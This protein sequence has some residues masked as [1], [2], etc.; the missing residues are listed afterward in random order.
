MSKS[1]GNVIDPI[2]IIDGCSLES[3]VERINNS[4]LPEKE[5]KSSI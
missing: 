4:V 2:E 5:K 1:K 3:I